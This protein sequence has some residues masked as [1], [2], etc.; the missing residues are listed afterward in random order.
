MNVV[1]LVIALGGTGQVE[2]YL[3]VQLRFIFQTEKPFMGKEHDN[4]PK[5]GEG[6]YSIDQTRIR[7]SDYSPRYE[8]RFKSIDDEFAQIKKK[9]DQLRNNPNPWGRL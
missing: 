1:N 9:A 6:F 8:L 7:F 4:Y 5:D 2:A 3:D